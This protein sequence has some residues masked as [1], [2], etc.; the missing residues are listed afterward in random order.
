MQ[1]IR[2]RQYLIQIRFL[3][4]GAPNLIIATQHLHFRK[5]RLHF[6][7]DTAGNCIPGSRLITVSAPSGGQRMIQVNPVRG[8][9]NL[10]PDPLS[11]SPGYRYPARS[12]FSFRQQSS[13]GA[14]RKRPIVC[15][16]SIYSILGSKKAVFVQS[17][18]YRPGDLSCVAMIARCQDFHLLHH[19]SVFIQFIGIIRVG[20]G[21]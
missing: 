18:F 14:G 1:V 20:L 8:Q 7:A 9:G 6:P 13:Q 19:I 11:V 12:W 4:S 10:Y 3:I 5:A 16:F 21:S 17:R 15:A 2:A